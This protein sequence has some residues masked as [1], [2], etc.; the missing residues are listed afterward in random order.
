MSVADEC[1]PGGGERLAGLNSDLSP[2]ESLLAERGCSLLSEMGEKAL[3]VLTLLRVLVWEVLA[4]GEG[5][6]EGEG[7]GEGV[8]RSSSGSV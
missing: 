2:G 6:G 5:L 1:A 8:Q 3:C 7:E 4:R